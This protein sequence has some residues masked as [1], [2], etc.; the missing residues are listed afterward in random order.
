MDRDQWLDGRRRGIGGSD[1]SKILGLNKWESDL[2][3]WMDK[4]GRADGS[5]GNEE[6][7]Y[8]GTML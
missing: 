7:M 8:W 3:L 1:I 4:T 5:P 6:A 2:D